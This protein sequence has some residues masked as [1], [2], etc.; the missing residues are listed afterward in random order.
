MKMLNF[1]LSLVLNVPD[2][3]IKDKCYML[4]SV[5]SSSK[6]VVPAWMVRKS[7]TVMWHRLQLHVTS[8]TKIQNEVTKRSTLSTESSHYNNYTEE[9]VA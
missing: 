6:L 1:Y 3:G 9:F 7:A 4:S 5:T 8:S 2:V